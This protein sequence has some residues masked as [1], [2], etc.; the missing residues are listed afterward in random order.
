MASRWLDA[1]F[2]SAAQKMPEIVGAT[3]ACGSTMLLPYLSTLVENG[4]RVSIASTR[5]ERSWSAMA[6]PSTW[7]ICRLSYGTPARLSHSL[8]PRCVLPVM[9]CTPSFLPRRSAT[10]LIPEPSLA[11]RKVC[12]FSRV[13]SVAPATSTTGSPWAAAL[14]SS[15]GTVSARSK[16]LPSVAGSVVMFWI[17]VY[18]ASTPHSL[19]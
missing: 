4:A 16:D 11:T 18:L 14:I 12:G 17:T 7:T 6:G 19:K 15:G 10:V 9:V 2:L 1:Q 13:L 8:V 3:A 5:P